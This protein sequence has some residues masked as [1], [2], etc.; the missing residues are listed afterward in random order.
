MVTHR[1]ALGREQLARGSLRRQHHCF[2]LSLG[3]ALFVGGGGGWRLGIAPEDS[4][5]TGR[6][7]V[8]GCDGRIA[9]AAVLAMLFAF[10]AKFRGLALCLSKWLC[11]SSG[12]VLLPAPLDLYAYVSFSFHSFLHFLRCNDR[13]T[14][15][16][17]S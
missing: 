16:V 12:L 4:L 11:R 15:N 17:G 9:H 5:G 8:R 13:K 7:V 10:L 3:S 14:S 6:G 1:H 2:W